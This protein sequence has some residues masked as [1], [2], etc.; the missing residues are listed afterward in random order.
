[1]RFLILIF[2]LTA[3]SLSAQQ[4]SGFGLKAG[5]NYNANGDYFNAIS[6]AK[7][8][9]DANI[10]Y[11]IGV[12]GKLSFTEFY[13]KPELVYTKT[14]SDYD[15]NAFDMQKLDMPLLVGIQFLG[16][17]NAFAGPSLQ[18]IIDTNFEG[19]TI[20]DLKSDFTV[21]L[22]FGL[23]VSIKNFGVDLRYERGL[24]DNEATIATNNGFEIGK[25]DTRPNQLIL[26]VSVMF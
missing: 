26:S 16:F 17:A 19:V 20:D 9:P 21:G 25:I 13:L 10:G 11:H 23:G 22:S 12:F 1:M 3:F 14:K 4:G 6:S 18:Y 2:T 8:Q 24:S 5:L 15:D 7:T